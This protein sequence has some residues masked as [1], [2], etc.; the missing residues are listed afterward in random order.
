M[1]GL[2][3]KK[4]GMTSLYTED[5]TSLPVTVLEV[6]PCTVFSKKTTEKDGYK[7][8]QL[9]YGEKKEK[10]LN[11]AQKEFFAKLNQ[12]PAKVLREF[13]NFPNYDE[14]NV[15]DELKV[16]LFEEGEKE[17]YPYVYE[18]TGLAPGYQSIAKYDKD[19]DAIVI[20]F[21]S[22]TNFE[23]NNWFISEIIYDRILKILKNE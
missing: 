8:L 11:K 10:K 18:H 19:I 7:S 17:L 12:K 9:G 6:G 2:L 4:I 23:G 21:T 14:I 20:Q 16:D 13:K 3:G 22:T 15:G 1:P 5:G